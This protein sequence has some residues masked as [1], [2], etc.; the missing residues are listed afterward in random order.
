MPALLIVGLL[1]L[2]AVV[3]L[4]YEMGRKTPPIAAILLIL[5]GVY[6]IVFAIRAMTFPF[7][8]PIG[9]P[10]ARGDGSLWNEVET[11]RG[12][13]GSRRVH[14]I[15]LVPELS[16][17]IVEQPRAGFFF[18]CRNYL[19]IG[20]PMMFGLTRPQLLSVVAHELGHLSRR[21]GR[22]S[23]WVYRL[24]RIWSR[25]AEQ[26]KE[27]QRHPLARFVKYYAPRFAA[28]SFVLRR[29]QEFLADSTSAKACGEAA[30][31]DALVMTYL[32]DQQFEEFWNDLWRI[33]GTE[34]HPPADAIK[35]LQT[36]FESL[37]TEPELRRELAG[38]LAR[39]T[40]EMD[41]HPALA[42]RLNGV[43]YLS[44]R[45]VEIESL[46]GDPLEVAQRLPLPN[47]A[48][49]SAAQELLGSSLEKYANMVA[50]DW[51]V[52]V[53][54][55]WRNRHNLLLRDR[56]LLQLYDQKA[57]DGTISAEDAF[58]RAL[59]VESLKGPAEAGA[60]SQL[61]LD[62]KPDHAAA[63]FM[64]GRLL[65][66]EHDPAGV[67]LLEQAMKLDPEAVGPACQLLYD[68]HTRRN[69]HSQAEEILKRY[70]THLIELEKM[71]FERAFLPDNAV[72]HPHDLPREE[73]NEIISI[74]RSLY[75]VKQA[76][77]V[78]RAVTNFPEKPC[79]AL[80]ILGRRFPW[81]KPYT[82]GFRAAISEEI[83]NRL[84]TKN[85]IHTFVLAYDK[86]TRVLRSRLKASPQLCIYDVRRARGW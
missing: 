75:P 83:S 82:V 2:G 86:N 22:L 72:W 9:T 41:T 46:R 73:L 57:A 67:P 36:K 77:L 12:K 21:D 25:I 58:R 34:E 60:L 35:K 5:G 66:K 39:R 51:T 65:L 32:R 48:L 13:I 49:P 3:W 45:G 69:Q 62:L 10:V 80:I 61:A 20:L 19:M 50:E 71:Q 43:G 55:R 16:A 74:C 78:K 31:G 44:P 63:S 59:I 40:N 37:P 4:F 53:A 1:M 27:R 24:N 64:R 33:A 11:L 8:R 15:Y 14:E 42:D 6:A 47:F 38:S 30:T 76:Y 70:D 7:A 81:W 18:G 52:D 28:K 85:P 56:G 79:Y 23:T 54:E 17:S 84:S 26:T 29:Q 68:F